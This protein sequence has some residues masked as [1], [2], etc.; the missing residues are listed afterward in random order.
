MKK[1]GE[2]SSPE[3]QALERA[4]LAIPEWQ[5][6]PVTYERLVPP[7]V[8]PVHRAVDG[9]CWIVSAGAD[10]RKVFVKILHTDF[11]PYSS[12]TV[13]HKAA[14]NAARL[15]L[16]PEPRHFLPE[17]NAYISDLLDSSWRTG[18]MDDFGNALITANV[19]RAKKM[20]HATPRLGK[21]WSV[22]DGIKRFGADLAAASTVPEG[23][24]W[25]MLENVATIKAALDAAGIDVKPAHADGL[26]SNIMINGSNEV[27]LVDFDQACDTDPYY[28]LGVFLNEAFQF[29][30]GKQ[31]ALEIFDG[32]C[33]ETSMHRCKLYGIADDLM[34][35]LWGILL[36]ATSPRTGLEYLKYAQWR[37][38]RCRMAILDPHF[39]IMLRKL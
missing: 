30:D 33:H 10:Q 28:D 32:H 29:D 19:V 34:W 17:H 35:G 15:G 3:E 20:F 6:Q 1:P 4:I 21:P 13:A 16:T 12:G 7:V 2:A 14:E 36:D 37:L 39:E 18:R 26:S 8:S 24:I 5:G 31:L 38:L 9:D 11:L 27:Q 22:F 23:D 25:W